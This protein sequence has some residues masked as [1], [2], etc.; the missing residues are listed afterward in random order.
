METDIAHSGSAEESIA[1]GVDQNIG[2]GMSG[3]TFAM[4]NINTS[5]AKGQPFL[6]TVRIESKT[7]PHSN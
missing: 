5:Q 4:R 6:Q 1:N 7:N 3:G 2:I